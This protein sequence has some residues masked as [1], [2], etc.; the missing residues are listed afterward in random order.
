[1]EDITSRHVPCLKIESAF[2][3]MVKIS[4]FLLLCCCFGVPACGGDDSESRGSVCEQNCALNNCPKDALTSA[5]LAQCEKY[6]ASCPTEANQALNC[7]I[8]LSAGKLVCDP[9]N[10]VTTYADSSSCAAEN[11]ALL[12]CLSK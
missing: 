1:M 11:D 12:V 4:S 3:A 10:G 8:G 6:V 2:S 7:R 9:D 5:C